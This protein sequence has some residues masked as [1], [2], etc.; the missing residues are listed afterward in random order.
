GYVYSGGL[1]RAVPWHPAV[2]GLRDALAS[3]TDCKFNC[4]LL[5]L[6]RDERD[7]MG[8]HSDDEPE[9]GRDPTIASVSLGASRRFVLRSKDDKRRRFELVPGHGSLILMRGDLQHH[10]QHQLP[11]LTRAAEPRINITF[12]KIVR[13]PKSVANPSA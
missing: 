6:Y 11:K 1:Y 12:R 9:L 10:W 5:N 4:A 8:W 2:A 3:D 13:P 7:S